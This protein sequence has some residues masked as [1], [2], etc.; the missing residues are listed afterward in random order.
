MSIVP[1]TFDGDR[2]PTCGTVF[3]QDMHPFAV[4][5]REGERKRRAAAAKKGWRRRRAKKKA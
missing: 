4:I 2:C 1:R 3:I 5:F